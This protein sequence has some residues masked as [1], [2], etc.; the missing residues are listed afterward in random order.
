M[1]AHHQRTRRSARVG[2]HRLSVPSRR[3][4]LA[5][6]DCCPRDGCGQ[7]VC[8]AAVLDGAQR[9]HGLFSLAC[10][11]CHHCGVG[12]LASWSHDGREQAS[13]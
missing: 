8:P 6:I 7:F 3:E 9:G 10:Y 13:R 4:A 11:R 12:W 2:A 5:L 1:I